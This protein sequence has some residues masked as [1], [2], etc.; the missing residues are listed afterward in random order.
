MLDHLD[1]CIHALQ[2]CLPIIDQYYRIERSITE[3]RFYHA[4]R[5]LEDL[6]HTQLDR[7]RDYMFTDVIIRRIPKTR[8]SIKVHYGLIIF[9]YI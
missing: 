2:I 5:N 1:Q 6:E 7:I 4:L 9:F 3:G 8:A